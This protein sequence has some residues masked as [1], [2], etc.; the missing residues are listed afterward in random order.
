MPPKHEYRN[1]ACVRYLHVAEIEGTYSVG[2][3][4]FPPR[5]MIPLHDHPG[6]CVLSRVLYGT[7]TKKSLDLEREPAV[8]QPRASWL[9]SMLWPHHQN[10]HTST[11]TNN[12]SSPAPSHP[13]AKNAKLA[14]RT[15]TE[16]LHAPAVTVLYPYEGN[17]HEFVAGPEGAAVLD[18]LLPPYGNHRDCTFYYINDD[19]DGNVNHTTTPQSVTATTNDHQSQ[20]ALCWIVPAGQPEDFHCLSG[21]YRA[22]GR[23]EDDEE[24]DDTEDDEVQDEN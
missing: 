20:S 18:V 7:V 4:V 13:P 1:G 17:L 12:F 14:K 6:M 19:V 16:V 8:Q 23:L 11:A 5:A 3:F 22:L 21:T 9:S 24:D 10:Y 15:E 2:V